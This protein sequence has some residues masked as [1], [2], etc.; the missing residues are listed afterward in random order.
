MSLD[1]PLLDDALRD[2]S[3]GA[4]DQVL[5][6][7]RPVWLSFAAAADLARQEFLLPAEGNVGVYRVDP[8]LLLQEGISATAYGERYLP[9]AGPEPL[10]LPVSPSASSLFMSNFRLFWQGTV[11][12]FS[13]SI[14]FRKLFTF[15]SQI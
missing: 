11:S 13:S 5:T 7:T 14:C 2:F 10:L 12:H 3:I 1:E 6:F 4:Q 9:P 15:F 8:S